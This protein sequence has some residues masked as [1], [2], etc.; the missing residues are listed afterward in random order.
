MIGKEKEE[1]GARQRR[2]NLHKSEPEEFG[3]E[4]TACDMPVRSKPVD[5]MGTCLRLQSAW[6]L[7]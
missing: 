3:A 5:V 1:K 2:K 7:A 4:P 6:S